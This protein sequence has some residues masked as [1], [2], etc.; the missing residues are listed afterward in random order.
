MLH[1]HTYLKPKRTVKCTHC[2]RKFNK[3]VNHMC[4]TGYRKEKT[5]L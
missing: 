3:P 2:G 5:Q 1:Y 4:K